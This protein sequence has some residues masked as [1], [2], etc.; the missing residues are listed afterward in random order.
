VTL[1]SDKI[2]MS[3]SLIQ[4]AYGKQSVAG[5]NIMYLDDIKNICLVTFN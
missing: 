2:K 1:A 4:S 5:T 3:K